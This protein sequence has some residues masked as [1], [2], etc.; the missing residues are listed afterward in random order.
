MGYTTDF[1][2]QIVVEPTLSP[3]EIEYLTKFNRTRR[4]DRENGPYYVENAGWAGQDREDDI[5]DYNRPPQGQ[6]GLWCQWIPTEN[7]RAIEWDQGEKFYYATEWMEYLIEHFIGSDPL[8]R[9]YDR[10]KFFVP[11]VLNGIIEA[12]GEDHDDH[13]RLHVEDNTVSSRRL[14]LVEE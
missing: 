1:S 14:I 7:G 6:P 12:H 10:T 11:H 2:G 13:W 5:R 9:S 3:E 8:A 4:M